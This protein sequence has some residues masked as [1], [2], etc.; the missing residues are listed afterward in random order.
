MHESS[1]SYIRSRVVAQLLVSTTLW[2]PALTDWRRTFKVPSN[3]L[4][5][6]VTFD[7]DTTTYL[8]TYIESCLGSFA[9]RQWRCY[10]D[11]SADI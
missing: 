11:D 2:T 5:V 7:P 4:C 9:S 1:R 6:C 3:A 8:R 10:M